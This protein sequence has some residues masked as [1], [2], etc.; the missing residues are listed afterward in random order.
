MRQS[1]REIN[2]RRFRARSSKLYVL[3]Q[4]IVRI[5]SLPQVVA[6]KATVIALVAVLASG[7]LM[8]IYF[9]K[10]H[11][12]TAPVI[13]GELGYQTFAS[14]PLTNL[15]SLAINM[16]D[17]NAILQT[18]DL[19][20]NGTGLPL[21]IT[22]Y[23]N[24][25]GTGSGQVG[26]HDSLSIGNDIHVSANQNGSA[27]YQ[28]PSGFQV[29]YPSNGSGGYT[30]SPA[31][32]AA[33]LAPV[34]G[35]GWTLTFNQSGEV[36]T[37]SAAGNEIK[38][39]TANGEAINYSYNSNGTLNTITDTQGRVTTFSNYTGTDVGKITDPSGRTIQYS[40]NSSG[41]LTGV[42]QADGGTWQFQYYDTRGNLNQIT[43]PRG[44][45]TTLGYNSSN[46][47][48]AITYDNYTSAAETYNYA[49]NS[50]NT[51]VTDPNSNTTTYNY[52]TTGRVTSVTD[53]VGNVRAATYNADNA[54][55]SFT[56]PSQEVTNATYNSL[57]NLTAVQN[58]SLQN[59]NS[60]AQTTYTYG[61]TSHPYLP[62]SSNDGQGNQ[63][64]FSYDTSGNLMSSATG[65]G[66]GSKT[67]TL[68]GDP[69]GSGGTINCSAQPGQICTATDANGNVTSYS[70]DS[71]G[72]VT[73]VTPP[74]SVA[75]RTITYDSLSRPSTI[76]DGN[77]SKDTITYNADN[78]PTQLTYANDSSTVKYTY[79]ADGNMVQRTDGAGTT[80]YTFDGYNR[81][82]EIQQ[83]GQENLNYTYDP[84]GNLKTEQGAGGTTTYSYDKANEVSG[85]NQSGNNAN[86]TFVYNG[87]NLTNV[88]VPGNITET[89]SYDQNNR[90]T[91]IKAVKGTTTLT[92]YSGS[93]TNSAGQD[94]NLLQS[95]T[96][97][98]SGVTTAYGYD[99]LN[100]LTSASGSGTGA[101][102]WTYAYDN[103]GNPTQ[104]SH[105][106]SYSAIYGYNANNELKTAGGAPDG[107]YDNNGNQMSLGSGTSFYYD[108]KNQTSSITPAG[109]STQVA[110]YTDADQAN[111]TSFGSTTEQNG[112]LGV[113]SDT[114]NGVT[115][116]YTHLP[117]GAHQAIGETMGT[118]T[119]YYLTD[120]QGS[121]VAVT[122][123]IGTVK[124][125]YSYNPY[126]NTLTSTGS[127][128][129]PY[130]YDGGYYDT[131]TSLYKFGV[132][133]YNPS[134]MR[135]TQLDPS[136]QNPGYVFAGDDPVNQFDPSG[137]ESL[138]S[139]LEAYGTGCAAGAIGTAG[140]ATET[141]VLTGGQIEISAGE[142]A[143][144]CAFGGAESAYQ[145]LGNYGAS[146]ATQALDTLVTLG[147]LL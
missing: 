146:G 8:T 105:N 54:Q 108:A 21:S 14:H 95:L 39:A 63:T 10:A 50:G 7:G 84:A 93:Y 36:Y 17:G 26:S 29:N 128:T 117:T 126:G 19:N 42:T 66:M 104:T 141:A 118:S 34:S 15:A 32:T 91:S 53:G 44:Y 96:N 88:Y 27:T 79:D 129:N 80:T 28:G 38:D 55:T 18:Q 61:S 138:G 13:L 35:G 102:S 133:Y 24:D 136:G 89:L 72:N 140:L 78:Q 16:A 82:S 145:S 116:Y 131:S 68:Q 52:D 1:G 87:G 58:P 11:A 33:T 22:R 67:E 62:S 4:G 86:E 143:L 25:L 9:S 103:N 75:A 48:T 83:S 122:D 41:Q 92:S 123:G 121:V 97:N 6:T 69:N 114:T 40:Y 94:T 2:V 57:N 81:V 106:G 20:I 139:Y 47:V 137:T 144:G 130:R 115:T 71:S 135:W 37:F 127:V 90:E 134:T 23:F 125:T 76:T 64:T 132:R 12:Y 43:D 101:N 112:L 46:Q 59:G 110:V 77:G 51:V 113:Y 111:R 107:T 142:E 120:M 147:G 100:R 73:S 124:N 85:V 98:V 5:K 49:Y 99:A 109:Q 74:G 45:T 119:Y 3:N 60:G 30:T 31:Y 70:Y 56:N 65:T